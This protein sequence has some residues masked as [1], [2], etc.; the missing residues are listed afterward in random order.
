MRKS[1]LIYTSTCV[2]VSD[3][4]STTEY[5]YKFEKVNDRRGQPIPGLWVRN[6]RYYFQTQLRGEK[7]RGKIPLKTGKDVAVVNVKEART[8]IEALKKSFEEG[9]CRSKKC[10]GFREYVVHYQAR[11]KKT[12]SKVEK[13][14]EGE[15]SALKPWIKLLGGTPLDHINKKHINDYVPKRKASEKEGGDEVA[16][17]S[18]NYGVIVLG[19]VLKLAVQEELLNRRITDDGEPLS[20]SSHRNRT[21]EKR[22]KFDLSQSN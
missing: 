22:Q 16:N 19:S 1:L 15:A 4:T 21:D 8:A 7:S 20:Y 11:V 18:V 3:S 9:A 17:R 12:E 10:P 5:T 13:T 6:G 2:H 14:Q